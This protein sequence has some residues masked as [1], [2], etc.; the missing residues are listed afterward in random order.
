[1]GTRAA[2]V[3]GKIECRLSDD[4]VAAYQRI[5]IR[6]ADF[7]DVDNPDDPRQVDVVGI[8][9]SPSGQQWRMPGFFYQDFRR[10]NGAIV[11]QG[12]PEWCVRFAATEVGQ[13]KVRVEVQWWDT[14]EGK[15]TR[16]EIVK[17]EAGFLTLSFPGTTSDE[18]CKILRLL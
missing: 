2:P 9:V 14:Y 1:M 11:T 13:W 4:K 8:F 7:F 6:F 5:E 16:R 17:S 18:A 10:E 15:T 12:K 3:D